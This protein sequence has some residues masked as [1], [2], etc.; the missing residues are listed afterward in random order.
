LSA[1]K[2]PHFGAPDVQYELSSLQNSEIYSLISL[3][4]HNPQVAALVHADFKRQRREEQFISLRQRCG[5]DMFVGQG[6]IP[7]RASAA[8]SHLSNAPI[9]PESQSFLSK[10]V[11]HFPQSF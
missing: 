10:I 1:P 2:S 4:E 8:P 7:K 9:K 3:V 5:S 11:A 6:Q